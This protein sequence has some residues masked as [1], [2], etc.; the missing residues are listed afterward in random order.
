MRKRLVAATRPAFVTS[1]IYKLVEVRLLNFFFLNERG[2]GKVWE[3]KN[4]LKSNFHL[5]GIRG[6][7]ERRFF[8][9][10]SVALKPRF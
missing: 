4:W 9:S 5:K 6:V 1:V 7:C 3:E 10:C 2:E 8:V